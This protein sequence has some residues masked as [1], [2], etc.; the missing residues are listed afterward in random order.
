[1]TASLPVPRLF[2]YLR[3]LVQAGYK[4]SRLPFSSVLYLSW[5]LPVQQRTDKASGAKNCP[6][7]VRTEQRPG[8]RWGW[9]DRQRQLR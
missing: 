2:V 7:R 9:C 4:V 5:V 1:M 3:R 6:L 8:S